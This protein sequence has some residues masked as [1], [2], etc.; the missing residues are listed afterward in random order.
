MLDPVFDSVLDL[1]FVPVFVIDWA[2]N[3]SARGIGS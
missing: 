1:I 3:V 2:T